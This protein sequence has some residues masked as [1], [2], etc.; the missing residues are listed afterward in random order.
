MRINQLLWSFELSFVNF[1]LKLRVVLNILVVT[2][3]QK[4]LISCT[5]RIFI[6]VHVNNTSMRVIINF[7]CKAWIF[8]VPWDSVSRA[9]W[10]YCGKVREKM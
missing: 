7:R 6:K 8:C 1:V 2:V 3:K 4:K 10:G 5:L 9:T